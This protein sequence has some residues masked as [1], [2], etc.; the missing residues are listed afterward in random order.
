MC[1]SERDAILGCLMFL[2]YRKQIT[3]QVAWTL[4]LVI[5]LLALQAYIKISTG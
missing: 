3:P 5:A 1:V 2:A 4:A